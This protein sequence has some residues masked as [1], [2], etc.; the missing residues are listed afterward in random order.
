MIEHDD[1]DDGDEE[2]EQ[3]ITHAQSELSW[4]YVHIRKIS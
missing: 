4:T 1:D 2:R 3:K